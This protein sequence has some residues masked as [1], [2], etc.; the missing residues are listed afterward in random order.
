MDTQCGGSVTNGPWRCPRTESASLYPKLSLNDGR[1]SGS[2][3]VGLSRLPLWA[4][5]TEAIKH[6][7]ETADDEYDIDGLTEDDFA[8]FIYNLL[9]MRGE[10]GRLLLM[11]ADAERRDRQASVTAPPWWQGKKNRKQIAAQLRR[12]LAVLSEA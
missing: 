7:W 5:S 8:G 3:T 10:F 1:V 6:G 11:L 9:E 2:I 12:C 4:F